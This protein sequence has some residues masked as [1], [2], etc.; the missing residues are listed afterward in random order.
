MDIKEPAT[1]QIEAQISAL[2]ELEMSQQ[3]PTALKMALAASGFGWW[4]WN[5][6]TNQTY[7]NPEWKGILG[8]KVEEVTSNYQSFEELV[9]PQ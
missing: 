5:L 7:H 1:Y 9:H 8:Y 3:S 6:V 2:R 4:N